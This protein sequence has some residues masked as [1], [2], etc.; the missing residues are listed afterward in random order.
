MYANILIALYL[1]SNTARKFDNKTFLELN[2]AYPIQSGNFRGNMVGI[3]N[4]NTKSGSGY[5][6]VD[7]FKYLVYNK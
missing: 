3:F 2:K 1:D 4:Y 6:D 5:I 7:W